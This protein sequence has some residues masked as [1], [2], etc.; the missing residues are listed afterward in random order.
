MN[1][2]LALTWDDIDLKNGTV[3]INKTLSFVKNRKDTTGNK[4]ILIVTKPKTKASI[5]KIPLTPRL[6][7]LMA[8]MKLKSKN[9]SNLV[10]PSKTGGY[11]DPSNFQRAFHSVV[12]KAGIEK[13]SCHILRHTF[14]TRC[15]EKGIPAKIVSKWLGHSRVGHTLDIYTH[16]MPDVEKEAILLLETAQN[17]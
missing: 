4:Y 2:L 8:E 16:I 11:I 5:R 6:H 1:E 14:A 17:I 9:T 13:C 3:S 7:K 10:F 15:F 12:E